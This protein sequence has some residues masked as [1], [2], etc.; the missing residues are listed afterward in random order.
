MQCKLY[1]HYVIQLNSTLL[2]FG[3]STCFSTED[4]LPP[5]AYAELIVTV[6][7]FQQLGNITH[8]GAL[9]SKKSE[10]IDCSLQD[11]SCCLTSQWSAVFS[12]HLLLSARL[13]WNWTVMKQSYTICNGQPKKREF[14]QVKSHCSLQW[15]CSF[16]EPLKF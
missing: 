12:H 6:T 5:S 11:V 9:V 8:T 7:L 10:L 1:F 16:N 4:S 13:A 14:S 15:K 3:S 2:A